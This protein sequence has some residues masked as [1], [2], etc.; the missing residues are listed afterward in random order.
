MEQAAE[1]TPKGTNS[2][3]QAQTNTNNPQSYKDSIKGL[4]GLFIS[5]SPTPNLTIPGVDEALEEICDN[6]RK[7]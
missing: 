5:A 2:P 4:S 7:L 6:L 1:S 3:K